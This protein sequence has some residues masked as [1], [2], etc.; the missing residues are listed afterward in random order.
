MSAAPPRTAAEVE[1]RLAVARYCAGD[2][3]GALLVAPH[4]AVDG[5]RICSRCVDDDALAYV[6]LRL[7]MLELERA[8]IA[9]ARLAKMSPPSDGRRCGVRELAVLTRFQH[10]VLQCD[11]Y[12]VVSH[13]AHCLARTRP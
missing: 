7:Y 5:A 13:V 2:G 1:S 6:V 12:A 4:W 10:Y 8:G 11:D 3:R 9:D